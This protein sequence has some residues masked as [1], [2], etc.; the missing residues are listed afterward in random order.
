MFKGVYASPSTSRCVKSTLQMAYPT[1]LMAMWT[2]FLRRKVFV[3]PLAVSIAVGSAST[4]YGSWLGDFVQISLLVAY[5]LLFIPSAWYLQSVPVQRHD[6]NRGQ[7][8]VHL[9]FSIFLFFANIERAHGSDYPHGWEPVVQIAIILWATT[10]TFLSCIILTDRTDIL[11]R[12]NASATYRNLVFFIRKTGFIY[13]VRLVQPTP[14]PDH[15]L[16]VTSLYPPAAPDPKDSSTMLDV[17]GLNHDT[18]I[19][20][21]SRHT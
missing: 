11:T 10:W 21:N 16:P 9:C 4:C 2:V 12:S 18:V 20:D 5:F 19:V 13:F 8:F 6:T 17:L 1:S 15:H 14:F 7:L 3:V